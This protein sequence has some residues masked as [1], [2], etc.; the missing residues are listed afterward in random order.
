[1]IFEPLII[2]GM[3]GLISLC[4]QQRCLFVCLFICDFTT[5]VMHDVSSHKAC[6][7]VQAHTRTLK[8]RGIILHQEIR[9]ESGFLVTRSQKYMPQM[10]ENV[11][12][13]K[14]LQ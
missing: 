14:K 5:F 11:T 13:V 4:L 12:N 3:S 2:F 8:F 9:L 1:M 10:Y 7:N 6:R